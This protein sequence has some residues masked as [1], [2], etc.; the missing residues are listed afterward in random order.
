[1][2][3][4]RLRMRKVGNRRKIGRVIA[5]KNDEVSWEADDGDITI[6]FPRGRDP[7]GVG[8]TRI[9]N[10]NTLTKRVP[11]RVEGTY[12]YSIFSH[13]DNQMVESDSPPEMII[14]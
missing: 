10:G 12:E 9:S 8:E 3:H 4:H 2:A 5:T 1:M 6:W 11:Q 13:K 7:L 14:R